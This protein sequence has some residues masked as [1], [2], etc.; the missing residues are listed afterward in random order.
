MN[1]RAEEELSTEL[2]KAASGEIL[3]YIDVDLATDMI[4]LKELIHSISVE[5]YDFSTGSRMMP[6]SDAKRSLKR[7]MASNG[8]N[9]L[10][11]TIL[12]SNIYDHQCGF[13]AF[14]R[15]AIVQFA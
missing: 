4:H 7:G 11:R 13:K 8:F 14:R 9:F 15:D 1:A 10:V 6:E 12:S 3:C 2:S 5:G